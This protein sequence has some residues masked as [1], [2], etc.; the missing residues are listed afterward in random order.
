MYTRYILY[1]LKLVSALLC[2]V[3]Y[4]ILTVFIKYHNK[5]YLKRGDDKIL[6]VSG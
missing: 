2:L 1:Y 5:Y 3:L 4:L 6:R